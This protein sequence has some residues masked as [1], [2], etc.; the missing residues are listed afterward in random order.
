MEIDS[1]EMNSVEMNS[2]GINSMKSQF[3]LGNAPLQNFDANLLTKQ[4]QSYDLISAKR[5]LITKSVVRAFTLGCEKA[6]STATAI[7]S[8]SST[9]SVRRMSN[10][11]S[12]TEG[13]LPRCKKSKS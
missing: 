12:Y 6:L 1:G 3:H 8:R 9:S 10:R 7:P 5:A 4:T 11:T 2:V 13:W